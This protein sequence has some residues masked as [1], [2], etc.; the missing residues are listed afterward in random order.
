MSLEK[1]KEDS[2]IKVIKMQ[3]ILTNDFDNLDMKERMVQT[4][5]ILSLISSGMAHALIP[6]VENSNLIKKEFL[7]KINS[8]AKSMIDVY[9]KNKEEILKQ[10]S[11]PTKDKH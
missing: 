3:Q 9:N 2:L 8:E 4:L 5:F 11:S 1:T 6:D 7:D 10:Y